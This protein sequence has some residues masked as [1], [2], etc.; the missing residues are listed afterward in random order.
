M[1]FI[2]AANEAEAR[3]FARDQL[4]IRD[5]REYRYISRFDQLRGLRGGTLYLAGGYSFGPCKD[6]ISKIREICAF[7]SI[8][9]EARD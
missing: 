4:N 8:N 7:H 9:I 5:S 3:R 2:V 1:N 6:E